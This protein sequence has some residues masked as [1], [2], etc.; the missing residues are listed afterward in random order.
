MALAAPVVAVDSPPQ[1][2]FRGASRAI[3]FDVS[4][5]LRDIPPIKPIPGL[6]LQ[7]RR[8]GMPG[9]DLNKTTGPQS[10]DLLVQDW[11]G[12]GEMP[13]PSIS[14]NGPSN[15]SGV[16]P[17]DP[18]GDVGPNHYVAMSNLSFQVFSKTGT[19]LYGPALNNTLWS[20][21]GGPCQTENA[22]DPVVLYDQFADRWLLTQFTA[23]GPTYYNC[24]ALSTTN[25]PTGT[26]YRW[27]FTT[28]T[29]FPDYPKYGIWS[30]AYYISTREFAG[31]PFAGVGAYALN[32]TQ[33]IAGNPAPQ[34]VSF[35]AAPTGAGANVG[36]GLLPADIE[37]PVLP[38]AG[39]PEFFLGTQDDGGPYSAAS[40][41]I[42]LYKFHVDFAVPAN[43]TFTL[44]NTIPV[45]A[46]DSSPVFCSGRACIPQPGTTNKLDHLGYRQRPLH[47]AAYRNFGDHEAIVTNQSVEASA[48][49]SG[50]RWWEIRSPNSSPVI[51]QEGT[52][53]P[54]TTDGIHRWMGSLAI[55]S[56]GNMALGYSVSDGVSVF[57]GLRYT[58]RL[59]ADPLNTMPQGEGTI[60]AGTGSQ[61]GSNRWGDYTSMN[62]D[63]IDDCTFWYVDEWVPTTSSV[64]WQL[65]IGAFKFDQCG[66]PDFYLAAS[67]L[68]QT[69]CA[70]SNA[71]VT[72]NVGSIS[73][74]SNNVTLGATGNPGGTTVGFAP[75]PVTPPGSTTFTLGNTG[76][77]AFGTYPINIA[78]TATASPGHNSN[79]N[80]TIDTAAPA[81][82]SLTA[83][84]NGALNVAVRPTFQWGAAVQAVSYRLQ[85][86]NSAGFGSLLLDQAGITATSYTPTIDL[87][88]NT[89]LYW[90]VSATNPCGPGADSSVYTFSTT[91]LPGDCGIGTT[92]QQVFFEN[93]DGVV[94]GWTHSGTGDTWA[95]ST[96]RNHSAPNAYLAVDTT[97]VSDQRLVSPAIVL[98][99]AASGL[100]LQFW[101]YQSFEDNPP[102]C[103]DGAILEV[104]TDGGT[105]WTQIPNGSLQ[106]DPYN[107]TVSASF[108]NPLASLSAWCGDPQD[109]L[110]SVVDLSAY[111]GNTVQFRFRI[112]TDTS[113]GRSPDGWHIDD[114]KVQACMAGLFRDGFESGTF[115]GW[116]G[117]AYN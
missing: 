41:A 54:G 101:N 64:G 5:P 112:G 39:T 105:N 96:T 46:F 73:G 70:G 83:P 86:S 75:N 26:Y 40:D 17:P 57:P 93:F 44:A 16:S 116:N 95:S 62:V 24:V 61:T 8:E 66:T 34:V 49:M 81:A 14:F 69:I 68:D 65:R 80:V 29:N 6:S 9:E 28:G 3:Q 98:P 18:V 23:N 38:P 84:A 25:D 94:T 99:A 79:V 2:T 59:S 19:S 12:S 78:G 58:G 35:L 90:R 85:V 11:I 88:S 82:P 10:I 13:A 53:A 31:S 43:S 108:S 60:I 30:D 4:P 114:V 72:V 20:G 107:G 45:G 63:P 104:T 15:V 50:I 110:N 56:A 106:T 113:A 74:F 42:N 76:A 89:V 7:T 55:D 1:I 109:W 71:T 48:T 111:A 21:F 92:P 47:R 87:P 117:G 97:T 52:Y 22:G 36:D 115:S 32:R 33:M 37:G 27:A 103:Y 100:T 77:A 102:N 51:F 91:A 67:P